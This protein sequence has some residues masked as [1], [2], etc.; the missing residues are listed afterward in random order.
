MKLPVFAVKVSK[1]MG[2]PVKLFEYSGVISNLYFRHDLIGFH[3]MG[4]AF[5]GGIDKENLLAVVVED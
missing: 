4:Q 2:T 5:S 1:M 3:C